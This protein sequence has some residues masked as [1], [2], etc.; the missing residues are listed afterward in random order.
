MKQKIGKIGGFTIEPKGRD[1][2][3]Q[4]VKFIKVPVS[5]Y[6]YYTKWIQQF[7]LME[8]KHHDSK[9]DIHRYNE[10]FV[11]VVQLCY[12]ARTMAKSLDPAFVS[13]AA[14]VNEY[15]NHVPISF[16]TSYMLNAELGGPVTQRDVAHYHRMQPNL[17]KLLKRW[18]NAIPSDLI[19]FNLKDDRGSDRCVM[20][21]P[22]LGMTMFNPIVFKS[23]NV[24]ALIMPFTS[25]LLKANQ[26]TYPEDVSRG[27][28]TNNIESLYSPSLVAGF[29]SKI[30]WLS[31]EEGKD[32][33]LPNT[34]YSKFYF[35]KRWVLFNHSQDAM[36]HNESFVVADVFGK[37]FAENW[38]NK[39]WHLNIKI[40]KKGG[41]DASIKAIRNDLKVWNAYECAHFLH[42]DD[43][44]EAVLYENKLIQIGGIN[45]STELGRIEI[46]ACCE[47]GIDHDDY[48]S[49][50]G[51]NKI[52]GS[53]AFQI[54]EDYMNATGYTL[55]N[56]PFKFAE[57]PLLK[58]VII[59]L[60]VRDV[61][62]YMVSFTELVRWTN[63]ILHL[64][65]DAFNICPVIG[66]HAVRMD[67][68][69]VRHRPYIDFTDFL[70]FKKM[71]ME[72]RIVLH[73]SWRC[74][75]PYA[76]MIIRLA[77]QKYIRTRRIQEKKE[78]DAFHDLP[79][80]APESM[81]LT[82]EIAELWDEFYVNAHELRAEFNARDWYYLMQYK[83]RFEILY[84]RHRS[85]V[86]VK[87]QF[88]PISM[89]EFE[90]RNGNNL[91]N[92]NN[93]SDVDVRMD[94][95]EMNNDTNT[96]DDEMNG[97]NDKSTVNQ[98]NV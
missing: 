11:Y 30:H 47:C 80:N 90:R 78:W 33:N 48:E 69:C 16:I 59:N 76:Q 3:D 57:I 44:D 54:I 52:D 41:D 24:E 1:F 38:V 77:L 45:K 35:G 75:L 74:G 9:F 18:N 89:E 26:L 84:L 56:E 62:G 66:Q 87:H 31:E 95:E 86:K 6:K 67:F 71:M 32:P 83:E 37:E 8:P 17:T 88:K 46:A 73:K 58:W 4:N 29:L 2:F 20:L 49:C 42:Q 72:L 82:Q 27:R 65:L 21:R 53:F 43:D 68:S 5:I 14:V 28:A 85:D 63:D 7:S 13:L 60:A 61:P 22:E 79:Q 97:S 98:P 81:K 50:A 40:L 10:W 25:A 51:G 12:V 36:L 23:P 91:R 92:D 93:V 55:N 96:S 34:F 94:N 39:G 15:Q 64:R 70:T 19:Q